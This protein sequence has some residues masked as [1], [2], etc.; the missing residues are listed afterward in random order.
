MK[1]IPLE[2][3]FQDVIGKARRGLSLTEAQLAQKAGIP[4]EDVE[5]LQAGKAERDAVHKVARVLRLDAASLL[6]LGA[7]SWHPKEVEMPST[8]AMFNTA[9]DDITVNSYLVWEN[10]GGAAVVFDTGGECSQLLETIRAHRLKVE[11]ILLTHTHI[12]HVAKID[13]VVNAT[14]ATVYVSGF[15]KLAGT[16]RIENGKQFTV[17]GLKISALLTAGH[18]PG[19]MTYVIEGLEPTVA[20]V[21]DALFSGSMGGVPPDRYAEAL[22]ANEEKIFSLPDDTI[23]CPGHGPLTTVGEEKQHNPFYAGRF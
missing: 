9:F 21:G 14:G 7:A 19:G 8:F 3:Q 11:M 16:T 23:V 12:D 13:E 17:G 6:E 18:S 4:L 10:D 22:R 1:S 20:I 2:D 15:E 5:A